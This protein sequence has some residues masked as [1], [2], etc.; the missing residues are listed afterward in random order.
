LHDQKSRIR[1][2]SFLPF[3][4]FLGTRKKRSHFCCFLE[5]SCTNL[6][7]RSAGIVLRLPAYLTCFLTM[8]HFTGEAPAEFSITSLLVNRLC[9]RPHSRSGAIITRISREDLFRSCFFTSPEGFPSCIRY[10]IGKQLVSLVR[11]FLRLFQPFCH[12][13]IP[14]F[15]DTVRRYVPA[16]R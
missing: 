13:F 9:K 2:D 3:L 11:H 15:V 5:R 10:M 6:F 7:L 8:S 12:D 16:D 14:R 4:S 1:N